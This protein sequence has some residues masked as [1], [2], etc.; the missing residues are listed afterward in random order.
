MAKTDNEKKQDAQNFLNL[1]SLLMEYIELSSIKAISDD[2]IQ[3][4]EYLKIMDTLKEL[5]VSYGAVWK[6]GDTF[7]QGI[8]RLH[9]KDPTILKAEKLTLPQ[10]KKKVELTDTQKVQILYPTNNTWSKE[11]DPETGKKYRIQVMKRLYPTCPIC[12]KP[13]HKDEMVIHQ[14]RPICFRSADKSARVLEEGSTS[15]ATTYEAELL[16]REREKQDEVHRKYIEEC[17]LLREEE[18][19]TD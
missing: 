2:K 12:D 7:S 11:K 3:E 6:E 14:K 16:D 19:N 9:A 8:N 4:G 15:T 13:I 1:I 5:Y 18:E 10:K 17:E